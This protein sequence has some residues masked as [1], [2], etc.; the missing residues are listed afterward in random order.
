MAPQTLRPG[1]I[2]ERS[3]IYADPK[4]GERTTLVKGKPAPPTPAPNSLWLERI[5]THPAK[6]NGPNHKPRRR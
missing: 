1:Q 6:P 3:R 2:V 4:S 5:D